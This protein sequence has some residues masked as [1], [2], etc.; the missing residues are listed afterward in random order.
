MN[1]EDID[2]FIDNLEYICHSCDGKG[3]VSYGPCDYCGGIGRGLS[4]EG[5]KLLEVI[6]RHLKE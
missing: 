5:N 6:R 1:S 3:S 4:Y 2:S